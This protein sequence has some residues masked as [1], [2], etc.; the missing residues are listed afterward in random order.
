MLKGDLLAERDGDVCVQ[1]VECDVGEQKRGVE[2]R[3]M[4]NCEADSLARF[5]DHHEY[6]GGNHSKHSVNHSILPSIN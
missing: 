3:K 2:L 6:I 5:W 4:I 1:L